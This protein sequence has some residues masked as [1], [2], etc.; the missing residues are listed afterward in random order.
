ML[1]LPGRFRLCGRTS[2]NIS[3]Y[4]APISI[5]SYQPEISSSFHA[6]A[7]QSSTRVSLPHDDVTLSR[8][9]DQGIWMYNLSQETWPLGVTGN[10]RTVQRG[11]GGRKEVRFFRFS[12]VRC[13]S[14]WIFTFK[15]TI[16]PWFEQVAN[17]QHRI[18]TNNNKHLHHTHAQDCV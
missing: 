6:L 11:G 9:S 13:S 7:G 2:E 12:L 1:P 10:L 3:I 16:T 14:G 5:P 18:S 15:K 4:I 8:C 17:Q